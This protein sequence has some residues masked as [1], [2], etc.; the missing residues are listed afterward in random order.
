[1]P[2]FDSLSVL[3]ATLLFAGGFLSAWLMASSKVRDHS[4]RLGEHGR[5]PANDSRQAFTSVSPPRNSREDVGAQSSARLPQQTKLKAQLFNYL[6]YDRRM[7]E[8][9]DSLNEEKAQRLSRRLATFED[10]LAL[11]ESRQIKKLSQSGDKMEL[12]VPALDSTGEAKRRFASDLAEDL[13]EALARQFMEGPGTSIG[14]RFN[15]WGEAEQRI[16]VD[17]SSRYVESKLT[18]SGGMSTRGTQDSQGQ[19]SRYYALFDQAAHATEKAD[20]VLLRA[21]LEKPIQEAE[22]GVAPNRS[23]PPSQKSTSSVRGPED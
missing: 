12:F 4:N 23:F 10:Q 2:R 22:Q 15:F 16:S 1:M 13:G 14:A 17:L 9:I 11:H 7:T 6:T 18:Y 20:D 19:A 3:K 8:F 21:E 5:H